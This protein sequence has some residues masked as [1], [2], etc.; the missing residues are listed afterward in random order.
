MQRVRLAREKKIISKEE[1]DVRVQESFKEEHQKVS[2]Q[3]QQVNRDEQEYENI[4]AEK[5]PDKTTTKQLRKLYLKLAKIYHPD[6]SENDAERE[7]NERVMSLINR[8]YEENDILTL[9][10]LLSTAEDKEE[11]VG[12]TRAEKRRRLKRE[13]RKIDR[14]IDSLKMEIEA[15]KRTE[16]YRFK[17]DVEEAQS[18]GE[19]LLGKLAKDL[20]RK[21]EAGKRRLK[22]LVQTFRKLMKLLGF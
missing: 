2:Q 15:I 10:R 7:K 20:K 12:E 22:G 18:R 5:E 13:K 6:K 9:E 19:D 8:A 16:T 1:I 4:K 17:V 14:I 3:A 21:I 11:I